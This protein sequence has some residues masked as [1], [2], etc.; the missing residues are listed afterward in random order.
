MKPFL[1]LLKRNFI[2]YLKS[3]KH[4]PTKAI[5]FIFMAGFI[6]LMC[7]SIFSDD[8]NPESLI[9]SKYFIGITTG[10]L[11]E[12]FLFIIYSGVTRKNFR[13]SMSDVNLIFTSP[14]K[15]QNV[16]L[17]GFIKEISFMFA[18]CLFLIFQLPNLALKFSFIPGGIVI[19]IINLNG[20]FY[21]AFLNIFII[22]WIFLK[23]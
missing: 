7:F 11:F 18:M 9:D 10:I 21:S 20:I 2:N 15:S 14:I 17:Y 5:P 8:A 3:I 1:Y 12:L 23:I 13:Y 4:K 19:S 6:A 16:L 22:I